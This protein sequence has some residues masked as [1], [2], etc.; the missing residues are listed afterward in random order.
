M[1][2][3]FLKSLI[4]TVSSFFISSLFLEILLGIGKRL[5]ILA[6]GFSLKSITLDKENINWDEIKSGSK[7]MPT[8]RIITLTLVLIF[9]A[10]FSF[11][12]CQPNY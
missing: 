2:K 4:L 11:S 9:A 7:T 1:G 10:R 8:V 12:P 5:K 3:K 6:S